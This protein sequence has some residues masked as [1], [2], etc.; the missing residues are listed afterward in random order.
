MK[1][2]YTFM[3]NQVNKNYLLLYLG[4]Q[5]DILQFADRTTNLGKQYSIRH[6]GMTSIRKD[7]L[8]SGIGGEYTCSEEGAGLVLEMGML[9]YIIR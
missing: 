5:V 6:R 7:N 3:Q 1:D 2:V 4:R 8:R 9:Y